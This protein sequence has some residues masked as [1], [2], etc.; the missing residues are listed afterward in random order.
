MNRR[1]AP[2]WPPH[3][4]G[5]SEFAEPLSEGD[6]ERSPFDQFTRW[7]G[8]AAASGVRLPEA[9]TLATATGDGVPSA[10]M[11]LVKVREEPGFVFFSNY[12]S[13]KGRE[14]AANPRAALVFY[15]EA[16]GRQ[17]R[18]EGAV[19]RTSAEESGTYVR[20][21]PR[22]SQLSALASPQS[23][24]VGGREL[25]ERRVAEL[26]AEYEGAELPQPENWGGF[27]LLPDVFEFW[28]RRED[29]L[30]DRLRYT[31]QPDGGWVLERLAP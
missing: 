29:R 15:W 22:G 17:V 13:R 27:R 1:S 9:A 23:Q 3:N 25:L 6:V 2:D 14:L 19:G 16:L 20:S 5:V 11:V 31:R 24:V 12:E 21:R 10:R 4:E 7:F 18:V 30:H 8:D 28:Q 26:A